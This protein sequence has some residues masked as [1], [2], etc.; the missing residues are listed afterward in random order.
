[1]SR[2]AGSR[3]LS[4]SWVQAGSLVAS[5]VAGVALSGCALLVNDERASTLLCAEAPGSPP[6]RPSDCQGP[7]PQ[8]FFQYR[9]ERGGIQ[10]PVHKGEL[11][12]FTA[13]A[14]ASNRGCCIETYAWKVGGGEFDDGT[15]SEIGPFAFQFSGGAPV[16]VRV[17]DDAGEV[18]TATQFLDVQ[19]P[20]EET[21]VSS[22][23][24]APTAS[25]TPRRFSAR[26]S[27]STLR[28]GGLQ[29]S[30]KELAMVGQVLIGELSG[31][32]KGAG[33]RSVAGSPSVTQLLSSSWLTETSATLRRRDDVLTSRG[34]AI[35][36][37]EKAPGSACV[38]Y[39]LRAETG[40]GRGKMKLL[41]GTG[42]AE[43][44][45]ATARFH[46]RARAPTDLR[47]RGTIASGRVQP[48]GLPPRC[49]QLTAEL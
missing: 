14:V 23:S 49:E 45:A 48:R 43:K 36:N 28:L 40:R 30:R 13:F 38:R 46:V 27:L 1:M 31:K 25:A 44:L 18:A 2:D 12:Y 41:G 9:T 35:A 21:K 8:V 34:L 3:G 39:S 4:A 10:G 37:F 6:P 5:L 20:S 47:L 17:T 15:E 19:E 26:L 11:V 16:S 22:A 7:E 24:G 42:D 29:S 33:N 32:L